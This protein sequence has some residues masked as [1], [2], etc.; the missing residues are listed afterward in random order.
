LSVGKKLTRL[1]KAHDWT[2]AELAERVGVHPRHLSRWE[3]GLFNPPLKQLGRIAAVFGVSTAE[4]LSEDGEPPPRG[5]IAVE[6]PELR[7]LLSRID[8]LDGEDLQALKRVLADMLR[9]KDIEGVL[10]KPA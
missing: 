1:R 2:Q 9:L 5:T 6:D 3:R 8:E 4:L 10:R 7:R